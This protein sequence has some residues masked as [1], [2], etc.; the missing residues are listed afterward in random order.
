MNARIPT[1]ALDAAAALAHASA[2][3]DGDIVRQLTDYIAIPAKS[4]GFDADWQQHGY[5]ETVVRNA[6]AW[7]EAR[8]V[9]GLSLEIV[10]LPGRT[11][12][13]FFE[14]AATQQ[15]STQT[16]LMYGHLDKQPE[17]TGWRS[18]LGPWTPKYEDG[19]LYGRG[20]ADDGYAVYASIAAIEALKSQNTPHPRIVGL[21]ETCEESGSYDLLPYVDALRPRLGEVA[22]VVCLDS[23]AGNY[24]QLWLTTSL[25]GMAGG[26]LKVE[27]LTEGI[28]SGDASGLV[29]SSFRIMRQVLDRLEDSATGRLLPASFHCEVPP[30]RL[31]QARATAAILGEELYKRFP[32][33]HYDCGGATMFALPTT[34]DPLQALL[35][36][37]WVPTLS[38]TGAD[39]LPALKDAGNVLRPYTAFKLS[40]RLPPLVDAAQAVQQ[41]KALLEDNAPYQARVTFESGGG[42][43]GWNAPATAPWFEQALN[44]ASQA[45]FGAPCGYIGQGGT[46]PLMNLLSQG[47]PTSQMMVCGVLGPRSNAHGPNEFLHVPYAKK[48]TA[49]VAQVIASL[50]AAEPKT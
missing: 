27:V 34:D 24:D 31:A 19:K 40:L 32:W 12:V 16:V 37:T 50:P 43:S 18:D 35:S 46:I 45:H 29:P 20:G 39:G 2:Q 4:P 25:R 33:A 30:E 8:K 48:L 41:L 17:F 21:V 23:G 22:L 1:P 15:G 47:F 14:V 38:V 6:A 28:H 7:V 49:A 42:A 3:W 5:I 13:L 44:E 36:R 10:R 11:P 26:T 9:A